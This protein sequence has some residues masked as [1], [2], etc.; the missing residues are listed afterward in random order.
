[1]AICIMSYSITPG[2]VVSCGLNYC[3]LRLM[4]IDSAYSW[5]FFVVA[6]GFVCVC[7]FVLFCFLLFSP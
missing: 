1:M 4:H 7:V 3:Y 6:G 2:P 5:V